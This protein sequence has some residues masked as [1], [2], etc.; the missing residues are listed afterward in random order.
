MENSIS[1]THE[2]EDIFFGVNAN[3]YETLKDNYVDKYEYTYPE[4]T[5]DTNLFSNNTFGNLDL[6]T[7]YKTHK[8]D[9]NK[10]TNFLVNDLNWDYRENLFDNGFVGRFLGNL[11]NI[12][13]ET[14]N[15]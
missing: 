4:I 7:N 13:Y 5:F 6:Q 2:E 3:I 10:F 8:Y 1:F 12:N 9:T 11:K 15:V 14:R